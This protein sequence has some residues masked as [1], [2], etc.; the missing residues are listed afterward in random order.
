VLTGVVATFTYTNAL[1]ELWTTGWGRLLLVKLALLLAVA[2]TGYWNWRV[3]T[4]RLRADV[5]DTARHLRRVVAVE[6]LLGAL[7]LGAT[8]VLVG[9]GTPREA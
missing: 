6:L 9:L 1:G 4:P 8:A 3:V 7:L 2:A 5:P